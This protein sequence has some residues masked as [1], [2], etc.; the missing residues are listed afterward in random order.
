M[1]YVLYN[2][3]RAEYLTPGFQF[4]PDIKAALTLE[5]MAAAISVT[6]ELNSE[7]LEIQPRFVTTRILRKGAK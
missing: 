7:A 5:T 3:A 6:A 2:P 1:S 4:T